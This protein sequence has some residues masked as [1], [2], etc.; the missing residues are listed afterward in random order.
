MWLL[1]TWYDDGRAG[2][3][4]A[5]SSTYRARNSPGYFGQSL[6][7]HR[8][9]QYCAGHSISTF[10]QII[11]AELGLSPDD[12]DVEHGDTDTAPYG[13]GTYA[14]RGTPVGGAATAIAARKIR[15]KAKKIAGYLLEAG[16]EDL[17]WEPG[18]F[19][20]KGAPNRGKTIQELAF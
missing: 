12:V 6:P 7:L 10:A 13:L 2:T 1:H 3:T 15:D 8:L 5:Q 14:S 16:E 9:C 11:A 4:E 17:E 18:R 19:Y 20:V